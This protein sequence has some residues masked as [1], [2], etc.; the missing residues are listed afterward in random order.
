VDAVARYPFLN[1][2]L[3][4]E[5]RLFEVFFDAIVTPGGE[6]VENYMIVKPKTSTPD[7]AVGV[8]VLPE[9]DGRIGV[10]CGWRHQFDEVVWQ[11][12][13][14]FI[15][16]GETAEQAALRELREETG[17]ACTDGNL[18]SLG[19]YLPDAGLI[20]G[21]VA[22]FVARNCLPQAEVS[23]VASEVGASPLTFFD[24]AE[25]LSLVTTTGSI[26]GSTLVACFRFIAKGITGAQG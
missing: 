1:R 22:L 2:R 20:E 11:A 24:P 25:L 7:G 13:A 21:R 18:L 5:N 19:T 16:P 12:P 17:C 3:A 4:C 23:E 6:A 26:G 10:M 15:D 9:V 8:C 14:G